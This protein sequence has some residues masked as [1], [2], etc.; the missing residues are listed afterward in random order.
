MPNLF[1][2]ASFPGGSFHAVGLRFKQPQR[3]G[4][5]IDLE[6]LK[7]LKLREERPVEQVAPH[8]A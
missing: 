6:A 5:F 7:T 4:L 3:G 2:R 8:G 1:V